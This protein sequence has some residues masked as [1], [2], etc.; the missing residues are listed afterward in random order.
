MMSPTSKRELLRAIRPRYTLG[1]PDGQAA[2]SGR[3][4][5]GHGLPPEICDSLAQS[6]AQAQCAEASATTQQVHRAGAGGLGKSVARSQLYLRQAPGGGAAAVRRS[7]WNG[8]VSSTWMLRRAACCSRLSAATADRLLAR[9]RAETKPH[10]LSTTK[11]GTLLKAAIP[12]RTFAEWDDAQP[13]FMEVDLV[14]HCGMSTAGEYLNSLDMI[15]VKTRWV[16]LAALRNRSQAT[17]T[18]AIRACQMRL[19]YPRLGLDSDN[20][21]EFIN[22]DLKRHCEQEHITFTRCRPYKKNDQAYVEQKNWTAVRQWSAT[23]ALRA[24]RL[25]R[26]ARALSAVAPVPQLLPAGHGARREAALDGAKSSSA[27]MCPRRR[28]SAF[29]RHPRSIPPEKRA[30]AS[31]TTRSTRPSCCARSTA[32]KPRCG[33]WPVRRAS[34]GEPRFPPPLLNELTRYR[35]A[36]VRSLCEATIDSY[37]KC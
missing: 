33:N 14:A 1:K 4:C 5:G 13:G 29:W 15:D 27:M 32:A 24:R 6:S 8:M 28:T 35:V 21:S 23:S 16:E 20:G 25:R 10:G 22:H 9:A 3:V 34:R 17:V 36:K 2:D 37:V 30:C 19:P 26:T 11:P 12:V 18:A 7:A 31:S